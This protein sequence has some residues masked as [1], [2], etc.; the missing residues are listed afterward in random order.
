M[1]GHTCASSLLPLARK[2]SATVSL[3]HSSNTFRHASA[4]QALRSSSE[5]Q[6][7][8][9]PAQLL[10]KSNARY[11]R[12]CAP[13]LLASNVDSSEPFLPFPREGIKAD[14]TELIGYTPMVFLNRVNERCVAKIA[15][16]LESMEPCSSVKDRIA[17]NMINRAEE[18]G[19]ISPQ[20]TTLVEPTSGNTGVGLAY[21]AAA[22]GYRLILTMPDTMSTE[23]RI[24]LKAFGA[25]L[26]LTE[27]RLGMTGAIQMAERVV[28]EREDAYMLQQFESDANPEIH[29]RTTGPEMWRDTNGTLDILIA[30]VGTGGTIQGAGKYLK[31]QNSQ[32]QL[33]GV[34]P[35]E[36]A[37]LS[38]E[39][40]GYHQI[41]GIGAGFI[42]KVL[43]MSILD[44]V[45]KVSSKESVVMARRM[46]KEEGLLVG[47][48]SGAAVVAAI[49][50][51]Q[52]AENAGKLIVAIIP[53]FGERYLSTVLFNNLWSKDADEESRMP[54]SWR[55]C[56]GEEKSSSAEA[57]L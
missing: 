23:R 1:V 36:S 29:Y 51:A 49:R 16:K 11:R 33:V 28:D 38:G 12:R 21:V 48:S 7:S 4:Q 27:G 44:E 24:L 52:R 25:E 18:A 2:R 30:G 3:C 42:P 45:V 20:I 26:I 50:L 57:K 17:L 55:D 19:H 37:V 13:V 32:V 9:L 15:C 46:A 40:P 54:N 34:E 35:E 14:A 31:E 8:Q 5:I 47:I 56:S 53:S 43:D 22:K 10:S 6:R 39:S 41:Q